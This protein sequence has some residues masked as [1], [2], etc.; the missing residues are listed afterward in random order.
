MPEK[1]KMNMEF[2]PKYLHVVIEGLF[3]L[4]RAEAI[5]D[6]II[7]AC[8][9]RGQSKVLIDVRKLKGEIPILDRYDFGKHM[10]R[11]A[12]QVA[13][14]AF[15]ASEEQV[16]PDRFLENVASNVGVITLVTTDIDEATQWLGVSDQ[17]AGIDES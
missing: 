9:E 17:N 10:A 6:T 3:N 2:K 12:A 11:V 7:T 4:Q 15:V 14:I 8:S 5:F 13:G 16:L 1:M